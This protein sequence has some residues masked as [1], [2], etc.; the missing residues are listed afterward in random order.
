MNAPATAPPKR[1]VLRYHG[2]KWVLAPWII[3]HFP[4]HRIYTEAY[5]GVASVLLRKS[6]SYAEV[7]N[8]MDGEVVN[9]FRVMQNPAKAARLR[10]LLELTPYARAE[11]ELAYQPV[12]AP[13]EAARR[14]IIRSFMGFGSDATTSHRTGFRADSQ[15]SGSTPAHDWARYPAVLERFTGRLQRVVIEQRG[16]LAI[17]EKHDRA[18][19]LHYVDPPYVHGTRM[20]DKRKNYRFELSDDD[21]RELAEVLKGLKGMVIISGYPS[22]LYD[23]LYD[24]WNSVTK[25]ALADGARKR[26]EC[27]WLNAAAWEQR[28]RLKQPSWLEVFATTDGGAAGQED[29]P[30][31]MGGK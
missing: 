4:E 24:G 23:E 8:D 30:T 29:V 6:R 12:A 9:V 1:P 11:F 31:K 13:I 3:Q 25:A 17:L 15:K 21:H 10:E 18:D 28:P 2:G 7:Y 5:G 20:R 26:T 14:T 16:A 22:L 19:C 27:L